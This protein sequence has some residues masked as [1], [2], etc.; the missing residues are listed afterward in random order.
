MKNF[1]ELVAYKARGNL[2]LSFSAAFPTVLARSA[3]LRLAEGPGEGEGQSFRVTG[4]SVPLVVRGMDYFERAD[5]TAPIW[6]NAIAVGV[7]TYRIYGAW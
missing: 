7:A 6:V 1:D 3:S 2:N 4:Y 5:Y